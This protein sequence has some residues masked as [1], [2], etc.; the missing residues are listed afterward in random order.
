MMKKKY[1]KPTLDVI[2]MDKSIMDP[3]VG[4]TGLSGYDALSKG[5]SHN[6]F[7]DDNDQAEDEKKNKYNLW[8]ED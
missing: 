7:M 1:E 2:E 8:S 4:S 3:Q 6:L 5:N